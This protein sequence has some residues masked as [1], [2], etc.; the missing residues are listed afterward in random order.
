MTRWSEEP[1]NADK[2]RD[3]QARLGALEALV[4]AGNNETRCACTV[5]VHCVIRRQTPRPCPCSCRQTVRG[6][7]I[8][9]APLAT[10]EPLRVQATLVSWAK[11]RLRHSARR[12]LLDCSL[13]RSGT[14]CVVRRIGRMQIKGLC[15]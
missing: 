5:E 13:D 14:R 12:E 11:L 10:R 3:L 7:Y 1:W 4:K 8:S 6:R 15:A 2:S 9:R